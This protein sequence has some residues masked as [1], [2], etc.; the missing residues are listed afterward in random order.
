[1][2]PRLTP[3]ARGELIIAL[4]VFGAVFAFL[5]AVQRAALPSYDGKIMFEVTKGIVDRHS[6]TTRNDP[7]RFNTPYSVYGIGTSLLLVPGYVVQRWVGPRGDIT[8]VTLMNPIVLAATSVLLYRIGRG[9]G[10]RRLPAVWAALA[11]GFLTMVPQA[12][13]ELFSEPGVTFAVALA[14]LGAIQWRAG[15]RGGPWNIGIGVALAV[16]FRTDSLILI[17]AIVVVLP[18]FVP[19]RRVVA[20]RRALLGMGAPVAASLLW[21]GY[22]NWLRFGSP[23]R[24][25]YDGGG[26]TT[27]ILV[28]LRGLLIGGGKSIFVF[29]PVLLLALVGLVYLWRRDRA[30]AAAVGLLSLVRILFYARWHSWEGG[31]AWGPRFLLPLCALLVIPAIEALLHLPP[32]RSVQGLVARIGVA[33]L[34]AASAVVVFLSVAVPYERW[35]TIITYTKINVPPAIARRQIHGRVHDFL[36]TLKGGHIGGNLHLLRRHEHFQPSLWHFRG[37]AHPLGVTLLVLAGVLSGVAMLSARG[38]APPD[39]GPPSGSPESP[40]ESPAA[41]VDA[42]EVPA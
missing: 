14:I 25:R 34:G 18:L 37:G 7:F 42:G 28:G 10:W 8:V 27:P 2:S 23:V 1:V 3:R 6:L 19:W 29:N 4:L 22:Y 16:L 33:L 31:I 36:F 15:R 30:V 26:F 12:S 39:H 32:G 11:F 9:I 21:L 17:G 20:D 41:P 13:T 5:F 24:S 35:W 38:T 40:T